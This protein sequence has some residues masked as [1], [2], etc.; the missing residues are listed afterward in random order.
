[1]FYE[2]EVPSQ[3]YQC[4]ETDQFQDSIERPSFSNEGVVM[5][6]HWFCGNCGMKKHPV[7]QSPKERYDKMMT[8][9]ES[10]PKSIDSEIKR[11]ID[12]VLELVKARDRLDVNFKEIDFDIERDI[13]FH[14]RTYHTIY[15]MKCRRCGSRDQEERNVRMSSLKSS[16]SVMVPFWFCRK[17]GNNKGAIPE[18]PEQYST[19][20]KNNH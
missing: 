6:M 11:K 10:M 5:I 19:R 4:G 1:M 14:W 12:C 16:G 17:C 8:T 18:S 15:P 3:C 7:S 13:A 2:R 20:I 9:K